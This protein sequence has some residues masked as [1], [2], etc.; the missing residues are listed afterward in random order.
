[1]DFG[2]VLNVVSGFLEEN[3]YRYAVIGGIA[4]ASY[5]MPRTTLDVDFA[6]ELSAQDDLIRF[7]ESRGYQTL[8]RSTG[9][10]NHRHSDPMWGNIDFVYLKGETGDEIF[11]ACR[12]AKGPRDLPI[13]LPK[14]EHL[15]A[16]KIVAMKNDPSR[17][18]QD[19][20]DI[21]FLLNLPGVDQ[22]EIQ[23]YFEKQGMGD[24]F[25]ELGK[26]A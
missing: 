21:R 4:L 5:G 13:L 15:A 11:S 8:H 17:S 9:Y 1:V 22:H 20:V 23:G 16:L 10:S 12:N 2:I 18:F 26:Q 25:N 6:V 3:G 7:L 19:M 14:P 24:R